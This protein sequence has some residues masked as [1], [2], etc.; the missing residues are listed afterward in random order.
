MRL[1]GTTIAMAMALANWY[2][3]DGRTPGVLVLLFVFN[4]LEV[5]NTCFGL[6]LERSDG[7]NRCTELS[8]TPGIQVSSWS[9]SSPGCWWLG[10]RCRCVYLL[11]AHRRYGTVSD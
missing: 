3:A 8:N 9:L 6:L 4:F 5:S 1:I 7:V 2:I 10:I 11:S